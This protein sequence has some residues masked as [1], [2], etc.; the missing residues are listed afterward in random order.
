MSKEIMERFYTSFQNK[1]W[2]TMQSCYH[3]DATFGDPVFQELSYKEAKAMWHM[4]VLAGKDLR[5]VFSG[6]ESTAQKGS[7]HWDATYSFSRTGRK[8]ENSIDAHFEFKEG[9]I[10][11]HRDI[12]DLWRWAGM[13]LGL[14][15]KLL[16]WSPFMR[17]KIRITARKSLT[18]FI[19]EHPEYQ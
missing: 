15:G 14:P 7:C 5:V 16:G 13:A 6:V 18:K 9:K 1:D 4:L 8:V 3:P 17:N 19:Q 10:A 2:K 12:F 11:K